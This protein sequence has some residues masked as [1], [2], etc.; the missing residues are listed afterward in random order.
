MF[1]KSVIVLVLFAVLLSACGGAAPSRAG[2]SHA[3]DR[4]AADPRCAADVRGRGAGLFQRRRASRWNF[5]PVASAAERDQVMQAGQADGM[6]NDLIST[7]LYN[8]DAQK[9]AI[10]RFARTASPDQPQYSIVA[11]KDSGITKPEDLKGVEIGISEGTVIA[12]TTDRLLQHAGLT[13]DD[14]KT[15]NVPKIPDRLAAAVRR[16][17]ESG[18]T[19]RNRLRRWPNRAARCA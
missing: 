19:C 14:I 5:V 9:I 8:K 17:A 18:R 3:E 6:I 10:V 13:K 11:S 2:R 16:Q 1:R 15:T 7:V 12:Y 4:R